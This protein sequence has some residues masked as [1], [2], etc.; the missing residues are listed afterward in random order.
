MNDPKTIHKVVAFKVDDHIAVINESKELALI[1]AFIDENFSD[2][3]ESDKDAADK[4]V[5]ILQVIKG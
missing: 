4:M 2:Y 1:Y 5:E 3:L